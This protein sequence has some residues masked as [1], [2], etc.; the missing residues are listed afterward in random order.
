MQSFHHLQIK[1]NKSSR[2]KT[3]KRK[4]IRW[5]YYL[6]KISSSK[7]FWDSFP[8]GN[9]SKES[10]EL[11]R[12][13]IAERCEPVTHGNKSRE[14]QA[15]GVLTA[16]GNSRT[17]SKGLDKTYHTALHHPRQNNGDLLWQIIY[18]DKR[19]QRLGSFVSLRRQVTSS[20]ENLVCDRN[21][22]SDPATS[23]SATG[24]WGRWRREAGGSREQK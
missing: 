5:C 13:W 4:I 24:G 23:C 6:R 8:K 17:W 16:A 10:N 19:I 12:G 9:L 11:H 3:N 14:D 22:S 21:F 1:D 15:K 2:N 7:G 20:R 18:S